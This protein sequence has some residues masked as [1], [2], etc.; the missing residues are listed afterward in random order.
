[1]PKV[2]F[3]LGHV[4]IQVPLHQMAETICRLAKEKRG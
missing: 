4:G 1:M 2:A 3:E